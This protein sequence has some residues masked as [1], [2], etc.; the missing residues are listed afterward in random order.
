MRSSTSQTTYDRRLFTVM[1]DGNTSCTGA[2][3]TSGAITSNSGQS[4]IKNYLYIY[5]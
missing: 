2:F 3:T 1:P 4:T 5:I